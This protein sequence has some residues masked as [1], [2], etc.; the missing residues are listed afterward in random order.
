MIMVSKKS[1]TPVSD[2]ISRPVRESS[3]LETSPRRYFFARRLTAA[4]RAAGAAVT[5]R[6]PPM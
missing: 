3:K 5:I 6:T 2:I 1:L 4:S